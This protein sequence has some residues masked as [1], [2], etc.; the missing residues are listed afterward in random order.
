MF[1]PVEESIATCSSLFWKF[2]AKK[3]THNSYHCK[4]TPKKG[5][6]KKY[7]LWTKHL[8]KNL[9]FFYI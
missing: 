1:T 6:I 4:L 3:D 5:T 2:L 9:V 8:N 7:I